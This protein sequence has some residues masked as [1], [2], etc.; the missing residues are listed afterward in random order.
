MR[1]P[2]QL[3]GLSRASLY[4]GPAAETA[5]YT[6]V[7][8]LA[9]A[10]TGPIAVSATRDDDTLVVEVETDDPAGGLDL[11]ELEDRVGALDGRLGP[12][13]K[14][15]H[16]RRALTT[17]RGGGYLPVATRAPCRAVAHPR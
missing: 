16:V 6:V 4:Y 17:H 2:C 11:V 10:A 5:A 8:D 1:R 7:A 13:R 12:R 9:A 15:P 14:R 3:L